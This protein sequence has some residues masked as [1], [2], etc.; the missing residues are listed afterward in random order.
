MS[1]HFNR[2]VH[3]DSGAAHYVLLLLFY[4]ARQSFN[5]FRATKQKFYNCKKHD[6]IRV[7][8]KTIY[9]W[10]IKKPLSYEAAKLLFLKAFP[11]GLEQSRTQNN[12]A[13]INSVGLQR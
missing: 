10:A 13:Q 4:Q 12:Y 9:E 11:S 2:R 1:S 5:T 8:K 7:G 3:R 6:N